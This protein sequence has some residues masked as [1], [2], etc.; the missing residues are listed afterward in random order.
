MATFCVKTLFYCEGRKD[1][2][3]GATVSHFKYSKEKVTTI[4]RLTNLANKYERRTLRALYAQTQAYPYDATLD[5]S[6]DRAA[7]AL[8]GGTAITGAKAAILPGLVAI[9]LVGETVTVAGDT[10]TE[11]TFGLFANFVGGEMTDIAP[12]FDKVGVWR[13]VGGV[14]EI[15][16]PA[17]DDTGLGTLAGAEDGTDENEA[18]MSP[19]AK[20]Q[21]V[22]AAGNPGQAFGQTARLIKR[23]SA[24]AIIVELLV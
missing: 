4:L 22:G 20:G 1:N 19:N 12:D 21:L 24:D 6:F 10:D 3:R 7:G 8:S 17:F 18:Y 14:F 15:L 13:G 11:R 5:S 16:S 9:K 23:L 2:L